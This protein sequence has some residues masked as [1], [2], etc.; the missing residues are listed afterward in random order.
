LGDI[1]VDSDDS[2]GRVDKWAL[3]S[4]TGIPTMYTCTKCSDLFIDI[5]NTLYCSMSTSNRIVAMSLNINSNILT[6]VAGTGSSGNTLY[7]LNSPY[8]IFVNL[9]YDLYVA[10]TNN[11]R[12]QVF[13]SGEL[14]GTTVAGNTSSSFT[15]TL[16][17]PTGVTLDGDNNLYIAD[18]NNN[19]IIGSGSNGFQCLVGCNGSGSTSNRL[20]MPYTLSFDS[21]GNMFVADCG[22]NRIQ[23]FNLITNLC[24]NIENV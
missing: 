2:T 8:G 7:M 24:G 14:N 1:Y 21:F 10:D 13:R 18:M 20:S 19:R 11:N 16:N 17:Y 22:N 3:N 12:I 5:S 9:N 23:K 4:T 15:I 6:T